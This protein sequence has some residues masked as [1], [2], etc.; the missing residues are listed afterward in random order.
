MYALS[1][2][3][4]GSTSQESAADAT[5]NCPSAAAS[6]QGGPQRDVWIGA[7]GPPGEPGNKPTSSY[8]SPKSWD[9]NP[10]FTC[11]TLWRTDCNS[12]GLS[13][14]NIRVTWVTESPRPTLPNPWPWYTGPRFPGV[15]LTEGDTGTLWAFLIQP[16]RPW[17]WIQKSLL[18]TTSRHTF[19]PKSLTPI[20]TESQT[21]ES[22]S[23]HTK[24]RH[25]NPVTSSST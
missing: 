10:G 24:V 6:L 2:P 18:K 20:D 13:C 11:P 23:C 22:P 9:L 14:C 4:R 15:L 21:N 25:A 17:V 19:T 7:Q 12:T 3:A 8:K 16:I 5:V 1:H